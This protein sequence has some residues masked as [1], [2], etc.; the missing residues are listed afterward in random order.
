MLKITPSQLEHIEMAECC[1]FIRGAH[2]R[3]QLMLEMI[4]NLDSLKARLSR[5]HKVKKEGTNMAC[6]SKGKKKGKK[7]KK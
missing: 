3:I 5:F 7:G 2:R 6:G 1:Y 4:H